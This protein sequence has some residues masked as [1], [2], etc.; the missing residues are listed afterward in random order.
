MRG[1]IT[2]GVL[3]STAKTTLKFQKMFTGKQ[4]ATTEGI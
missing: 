3:L 1:Y 4:N 2:C